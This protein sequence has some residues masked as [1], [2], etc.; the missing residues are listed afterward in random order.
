MAKCL[1]CNKEQE[2]IICNACLGKGAEEIGKAVK[3]V[4]PVVLMAVMTLIT[5][6]NIK[7]KL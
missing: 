1:L 6:K 3:N 5:G 4:G 7:F 2:H